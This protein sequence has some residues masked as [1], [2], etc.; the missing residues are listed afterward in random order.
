MWNLIFIFSDVS[1]IR[2]SFPLTFLYFVQNQIP[3]SFKIEEA[4]KIY[5]LIDFD[6]P[7]EKDYL[8]FE[9]LEYATKFGD[10]EKSF[11]LIELK[12]VKNSDIITIT[13]GR[14][15][16]VERIR[17]NDIKKF[18]PSV[19]RDKHAVIEY[20]TKKGTLLLQNKSLRSDTLIAIKDVLK[21]NRNKIHLQI[22]RTF[23][24]ACLLNENEI[25]EIKKIKTRE[26]YFN[27]IIVNMKK[28]EGEE[29][30]FLSDSDY[31]DNIGKIY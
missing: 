8:F 30:M 4:D 28:N 31:F 26:E 11:H 7:K 24:E 20:N 2:T 15:G 13:I 6:K 17:D 3:L 10:Y 19:S 22:G 23:V 9:S 27:E 1:K 29:T 12:N 5:E 16:S 21:I 25:K 18:E 14:D